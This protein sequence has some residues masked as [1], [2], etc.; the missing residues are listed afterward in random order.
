[1]LACFISFRSPVAFGGLTAPSQSSVDAAGHDIGS[2]ALF[3]SYALDPSSCCL[4]ADTMIGGY[5]THCSLSQHRNVRIFT[6]GLRTLF[7]IINEK[8]I[9]KLPMRT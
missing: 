7:N 4:N 6:N 9:E 2:V 3:L 1:M 5:E 8:L